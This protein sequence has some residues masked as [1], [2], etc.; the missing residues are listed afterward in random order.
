[1]KMVTDRKI[2]PVALAN[3]TK[4]ILCK[5]ATESFIVQNAIEEVNKQVDALRD[6]EKS[7]VVTSANKSQASELGVKLKKLQKN[8]DDKRKELKDEPLR[9][10]QRIDGM[11]Q[12]V[13]LTIKTMTDSVA[14]KLG[15]VIK[16]ERRKAQE[17]AEK[18]AEQARKRA[19]E[20]AKKDGLSK[21]QANNIGSEVASVVYSN[22][23]QS[24]PTGFVTAGG[25]SKLN[26][27]KDFE[28]LNILDI[29]INFLMVDRDKVMAAI[30]SG[31]TKIPGIN[32]VDVEKIQFR[33]R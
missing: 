13:I 27:K 6:E 4:D 29:P 9:E 25:S 22:V 24:S 17:E 12:P 14:V 32:I 21:H 20:E 31:V 8:V 33:S 2:G 15:L 16:E 11:F 1:M 26:T 10:C 5:V 30:N 7:L 18:L 23:S 19:I 28:V 3:R